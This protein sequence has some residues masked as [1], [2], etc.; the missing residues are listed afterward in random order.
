MAADALAVERK[1]AEA[2]ENSFV[3]RPPL[4]QRFPV[5][6]VKAIITAT[7]KE[8]LAEAAYT[9]ELGREVAEL[10]RAR[11]KGQWW[12]DWVRGGMRGGAHA[13]HS[14]RG[15]VA[16][17]SAPCTMSLP[18]AMLWLWVRG[19]WLSCCARATGCGLREL[20]VRSG[21]RVR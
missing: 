2:N 8:R 19:R 13:L 7:L 1:K 9:P 4:R 18:R 12:W 21:L 3:V 20:F 14:R 5:P 11:V 17:R 10:L 15:A 6:A 16:T